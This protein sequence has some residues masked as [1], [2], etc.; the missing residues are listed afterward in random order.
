MA[1]RVC[2]AGVTGWTGSEVPR[3]ILAATELELT[4]ANARRSAGSDLG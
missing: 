4:G 2:V 1:I 3:A